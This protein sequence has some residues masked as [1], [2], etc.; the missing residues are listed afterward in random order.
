[1]PL[2]SVVIPVYNGEKTIQETVDSVLKQTFTD[3]ELL[4]IN[5]GSQDST[6]EILSNIQ[7]PRLKILSYPNAG[8]AASRNRG[9][10]QATGEFIA[11]LD[12]DDLWTTDKLE[13]QLQA[14]QA[15]PQAAVAY[16]WTDYINDAS[17]F[18][19]AGTHMTRNGSVLGQLLV[20]N[21]VENGSNPLIRKQALLEVG[22]FDESLTAAEDW[23]MWLRLAKHYEFVGVRKVQI[24]YR[25]TNSMSSNVV[26]QE[27]ECLKILNR[28]FDQA[29]EAIQ[30]LRKYSYANL[31]KYL[32]FKAL[33]GPPGLQRGYA[34]ARCLWHSIQNNPALLQQRRMVLSVMF[35][36]LKKAL[37]PP[38]SIQAKP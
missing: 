28:A 32:T 21:F 2:I 11:F 17:Q 10:A 9:T 34:A 37:T 33:D 31:Y 30:Q 13:A 14:L 27:R 22:D 1:M 38:L 16:S 5:D 3:F 19:Q 8:L 18:I 24:L 29:P 36:I 12:A 35:K 7:D 23:D 20:T 4:I 6:L 15:N 26:R 25:R